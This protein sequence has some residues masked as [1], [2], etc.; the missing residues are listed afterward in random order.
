[1]STYHNT[2]ESSWARS[3]KRDG[4]SAAYRRSHFVWYKVAITSISWLSFV[5]R[6]QEY[7][8]NTTKRLNMGS[9]SQVAP[10][11]LRYKRNSPPTGW[12][13]KYIIKVSCR[14]MPRVDGQSKCFTYPRLSPSYDNHIKRSEDKVPITYIAHWTEKSVRHFGAFSDR[15]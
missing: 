8:R 14:C 7:L 13:F 3:P 5:T 1:M 2:G 15:R 6:A 10:S 4:D 9:T 12:R 11:W